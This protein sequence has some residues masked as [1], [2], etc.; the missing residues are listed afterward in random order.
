[1]D[2]QYH[3][4]QADACEAHYADVARAQELLRQRRPDLPAVMAQVGASFIRHFG[5]SFGATL[6]CTQDALALSFVRMAA[7]HGSWG[8]DVHDYHNEEHALE[9]LNGRLAR[10]RLSWGWQGLEA[11]EWILLA[12][13]ATCHD[14][15][16]REE[17]GFENNVGA[18]ERASIAEAHRILSA[19]GFD[20]TRDQEYFESLAWMIAGST[21]DARPVPPVPINSADVVN[22]GGS[23]SSAL[24]LE[25]E[26]LH[27]DYQQSAELARR[28]RLILYAADLDTANVGE[29][30]LTFVN[31]S[32]R[33]VREREMR[34][35][36][37]L[38]Q[39]ESALEVFEF[40][41]HGQER[42]FYKLHRF[43]S[44]LGRDIFGQGKT[45]NSPKL[46][47]L[48]DRL[49]EEFPPE[50]LKHATG[51]QVIDAFSAQAKLLA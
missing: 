24:L 38:H 33:L 21:F 46:K 45:I 15:R 8:A 22:S 18:N 34:A 49:R 1:M 12:L 11:Q 7:R 31:S 30:F 43:V 40:L 26:A 13:F 36:R 42:Y 4:F 44:K 6:A 2:F 28:A 5:D 23:L 29:P 35:G 14:L 9:V 16:Q 20:Q 37:S 27:P 51:L 48:T 3:Q 32:L 50:K 17:P 25:F 41:T 39:S 19:A 10:V 47:K